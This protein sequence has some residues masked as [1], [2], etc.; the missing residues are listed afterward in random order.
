MPNLHNIFNRF[1]PQS[2]T[3]DKGKFLYRIAWAI[4]ILVAVIGFVIG[5]IIMRAAQSEN[6]LNE[7]VG[8]LNFQNITLNDFSIGLIFMIVAV[9]ELTKIPMATAVYYSE[10]WSWR[11]IFLIGL[12][13]INISTFETIATGFERVNRARTKPVDKLIVEYNGLNKKIQELSVSSSIRSEDIQLELDLLNKQ[14][15]ENQNLLNE[16]NLNAEQQL[17]LLVQAS[18]NKELIDKLNEEIK[19]IRDENK[20][21]RDENIKINEQ[22][23]DRILR[24]SLNDQIAANQKK[25]E[26]NDKIIISKTEEIKVI[27]DRSNKNNQS[28]KDLIIKERDTANKKINDLITDID[29]NIKLAQ[30]RKKNSTNNLIDIEAQI[31]SYNK[32]KID[33]IA[34]I[35]DL[36]ADNQVFR[37]AKWLKGWFEFDYN[38]EIIK[39]N[40]LISELQ[41]KKLKSSNQSNSFLNKFYSFFKEEINIEIIDQQINFYK[42][43]INKFNILLRSNNNPSA[44]AVYADIPEG[45]RIAAFWLWFGVLSFVISITG[46]MLAFASL[47]LLD[48]RLHKMRNKPTANWSG[49]SKRIS[50]FFVLLNK[51]IWGRIKRFRDPVIKEIEIEKIVEKPVEIE[52]V[53]E[54]EVI[55]EKIVDKPIEIEKIVY[56]KVE[57][58]KVHET[59]RKEIVYVPLPT[60]DEELLKRGPFKA[61][62][63]DQNNKKKK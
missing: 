17:N 19:N 16:N 42:D 1:F 44:N 36:A 40:K 30:E 37:V 24:K 5:L 51:F 54:K 21:L 60:D 56:Q 53:V 12:L 13:L 4:E 23:K 34:K 31:D 25:I 48:P 2:Q 39:R 14:R 3:T 63:Y 20:I 55:V 11:V 15:K 52:K 62:D 10:R 45:A 41:N 8:F 43:E 61:A 32:A 18:G 33:L 26:E 59:V 49:V 22:L 9:V 7:S 58:P 57:V 28:Q 46:T 29:N 35:D 38:K 27:I 50:S 6:G 47:V